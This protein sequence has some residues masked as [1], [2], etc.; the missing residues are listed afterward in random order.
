MSHSEGQGWKPGLPGVVGA[1]WDECAGR[2]GLEADG[3]GI[4]SALVPMEGRG[5]G[6]TS[7]VSPIPLQPFSLAYHKLL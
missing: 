7:S 1:A 2:A 4:C 6:L 5:K 3:S